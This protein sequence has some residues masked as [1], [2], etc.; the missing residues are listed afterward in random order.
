MAAA[1]AGMKIKGSG[2]R[3]SVFRKKVEKEKGRTVFVRQRLLN[4]V[5]GSMGHAAAFEDVKPFLHPHQ[6]NLPSPTPECSYLGYSSIF[7]HT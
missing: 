7:N 4:V 1:K 3:G 2:D 5:D 6:S